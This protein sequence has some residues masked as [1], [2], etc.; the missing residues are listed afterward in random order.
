MLSYSAKQPVNLK[1][2]ILMYIVSPVP[3]TKCYK[4]SVYLDMQDTGPWP[5]TIQI[6]YSLSLNA[7]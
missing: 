7:L 2:K 5:F 3:V 4:E 6:S 1:L